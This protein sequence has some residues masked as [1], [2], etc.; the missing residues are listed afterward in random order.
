MAM[1]FRPKAMVLRYIF[2]PEQFCIPWVRADQQRLKIKIDDLF[3]DRRRES[4][5]PDAD[6]S[7]VCKNFDDE[8]AVKS[9]TLHGT[10]RRG[11]Q[12]HGIGAEVGRKRRSFSAPLH[13]ASA[14]FSDFHGL[15]RG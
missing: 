8:P 12:V 4:S 1:P 14:Q 13:H 10:S 7:L 11:D 9:E 5:V 2:L 15:R 3:G 6:Y